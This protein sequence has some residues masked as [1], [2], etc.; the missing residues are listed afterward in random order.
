MPLTHL[1]VLVDGAEE[2]WGDPQ[3][4]IG[5]VVPWGF[6]LL[7]QA[8]IAGVPINAGGMLGVYGIA[9]SRKTSFVINIIINQ[10]LSGRIPPGYNIAYDTLESGMTIERIANIFLSILATKFL[11]YWHWN[12]TEERDIRKLLAMGLPTDMLPDNLVMDVRDNGRRETV[13]RPE[14]FQI[15]MPPDGTWTPRQK[16]AIDMA[17]MKAVFEFEQKRGWEPLDKSL[18]KCGYDI[19]SINPNNRSEIRHIE[20]KGHA[21]EEPG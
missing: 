10:C 11:I 14:F 9:G 12:E 20:V 19:E 4:N 1:K 17:A 3:K 5:R 8:L 21:G 13:V 2:F 15:G 6:G 7:D 18:I 16:H